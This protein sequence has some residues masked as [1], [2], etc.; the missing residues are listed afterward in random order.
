[1]KESNEE[2]IGLFYYANEKS[3]QE[4]ELE[5]QLD[6]AGLSNNIRRNKDV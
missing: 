4:K 2:R 1:M 5:R 6:I 3:V